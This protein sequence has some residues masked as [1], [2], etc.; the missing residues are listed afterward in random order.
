MLMKI[1]V[2]VESLTC[3]TNRSIC[4]QSLDYWYL[5]VFGG[6]G[7]MLLLCLAV[8]NDPVFKKIFIGLTIIVLLSP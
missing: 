2:T 7:L 3:N 1:G 6:V 5:V 4:T 8:K